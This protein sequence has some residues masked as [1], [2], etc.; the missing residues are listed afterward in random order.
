MENINKSIDSCNRKSFEEYKE[1]LDMSLKLGNNTTLFFFLH[2]QNF[3]KHYSSTLSY[4][5]HF[6]LEK[7]F[8]FSLEL[9]ILDIS[10]KILKEMKSEFGNE[11]KLKRMEAQ[12]LENDNK[13]DDSVAMA[14]NIYKNLIRYNQE[15]RSTLKRYLVFLKAQY[16]FEGLKKYAELWNEYLKVYMDDF[17]AWSELSDIYILNSNFNQAIFC[18]EEVL[19]HTPNN[20]TIYT[21]IGDML[22]SFNNTD[23]AGKALKYYSQSIMIKPT[24]R[25]FWGIIHTTNVLFKTNKTLEPKIKQL[26]KIA[27]IQLANFYE[28]SPIKV[29]IDQ[30]YDIKSD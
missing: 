1:W 18:L 3:L 29:N 10:R 15:D 7:L 21:K 28:N 20:Y 9:K 25:A 22:S 5:K 2:I 27:K 8:Y 12:L 17:E 23:S 26:F 19:L 14:N 11:P 6:Y 30:F 4:Q 13:S 24:P 16:D